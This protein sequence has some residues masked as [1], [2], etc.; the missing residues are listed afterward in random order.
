MLASTDSRI[1][2]LG[3]YNVQ[4]GQSSVSGLSSGAF[5]TVQLHLAHSASFAGAGIIAGGP[6]RCAESY[7]G[8]AAQAE[9]A[10]IESSLYIC[11][12]P[13]VPQTTPNAQRLAALADATARAG[14][15]D[16]ISNLADDRVYIFT[17]SRD[18]VVYS[19]VVARTRLFYELLGVKS[20]NIAYDDTVPAGHSIVTDN[21]EDSQLETNQPPYI[22]NGGFMQSH[23]ILR[24]IY[25]G[26]KPPAEW[27]S[28]RIVR[29][30][31]TEFFGNDVRASMSRFGYAY[32]PRAVEEER[33]PARVHIALHGCKQGYN[34][35]DYINGRADISNRPPYGNRYI[36]TTGYNHIAD[37]NDIIVLY[38]QA[39]GTDNGEIQNPDGCWDWW[40]YTSPDPQQP[41]YYSRDAIQIKAIHGM[42]QRLGG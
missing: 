32:V 3:S 13:L 35:V 34:Y 12:N 42:L 40:G 10:Y 28:G 29:F 30:D 37:S 27:L 1:V 19:D 41:D 26:L 22:N 6:F 25:S 11:M 36:T 39:Q 5:M 14:R 17:G 20:T 23:D 31:Q 2:Q 24:H 38:P 4:K 33:V 15:I 18:N 16:A 8:V 21:P 9:D 7:R